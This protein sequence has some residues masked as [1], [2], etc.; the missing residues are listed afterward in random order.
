MLCYQFNQYKT[1][2][3]SPAGQSLSLHHSTPIHH[4]GAGSRYSLPLMEHEA[5]AETEIS[6]PHSSSYAQESV[7]AGLPLIRTSHAAV[8]AQV[9][10]FC[11]CCN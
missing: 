3:I 7:F 4:L 9:H 1:I 11:Y 10:W 5:E 2:G 8:P 6:N